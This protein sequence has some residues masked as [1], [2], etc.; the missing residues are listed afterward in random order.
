MSGKN[1][2]KS[3]L[4]SL[5]ALY[6]RIA[7][8]VYLPYLA[9]SIINNS[10][11]SQGAEYIFFVIV[12]IAFAIIGL[13]IL[14]TAARAIKKG[15]FLNGAADTSIAESDSENEGQEERPRK[16]IRFDENDDIDV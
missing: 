1:E 10:S 6:C 3:S 7:I 13:I 11:N 8:G 15:E 5:T 2:K 12:A 9:Y 4:P 16:R 14:F